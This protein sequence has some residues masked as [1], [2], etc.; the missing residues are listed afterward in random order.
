M[1]IGYDDQAD[2]AAVEGSLKGA[3]LPLHPVDPPVAA[4][5]PR[6]AVA[7]GAA[8]VRRRLVL[9][10]AVLGAIGLLHFLG[11]SVRR[12]A[13]DLAVL[14]AIGFVHGQVR[15]P[16]WLRPSPSPLPASSSGSRSASS[17]V[18]SSGWARW[19]H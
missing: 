17:S 1:A 12:R 14:K 3:G 11:L 16:W 13:H 5:L 19:P 4:Q 6:R 10:L 7:D 2:V 15:G 18:A 9:L 8:G